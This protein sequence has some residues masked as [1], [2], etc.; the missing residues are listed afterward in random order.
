MIVLMTGH[1]C[2]GKSTVYQEII[3]HLNITKIDISDIHMLEGNLFSREA[4]FYNEEPR[5]YHLVSII[6]SS[7]FSR[8]SI[9][10]EL[11]GEESWFVKLR[12]FLLSLWVPMVQVELERDS[13]ESALE[14]L[15]ERCLSKREDYFRVESQGLTDHFGQ[16]FNIK[17]KK[18]ITTDTNCSEVANYILCK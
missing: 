6:I 14:C 1:V 15:R 16:A 10:I 2:S 12:S 7:L 11:I 18:F 5:F 8:K 3:K 13:I 9:Y 17:A 4:R